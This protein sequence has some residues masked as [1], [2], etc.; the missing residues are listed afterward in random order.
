MMV[1]NER[2]TYFVQSLYPLRSNNMPRSHETR[3]NVISSNIENGVNTMP[4]QFF[5]IAWL[6]WEGMLE[7]ITRMIREG[8]VEVIPNHRSLLYNR[9]HRGFFPHQASPDSGA[10]AYLTSYTNITKNYIESFENQEQYSSIVEALELNSDIKT[11]FF[12]AF[13]DPVSLDVINIAVRLNGNRFCANGLISLA[14]SADGTRIDPLTRERFYL[15]D[16]QPDRDTN[17]AIKNAIEEARD[18]Q[19]ALAGSSCNF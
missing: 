4:Q 17:E 3:E 8:D 15:R 13:I 7:N 2:A 16:I 12:N 10:L 11:Q 14:V 6:F 19:M 18:A 1:V 5:D 9:S